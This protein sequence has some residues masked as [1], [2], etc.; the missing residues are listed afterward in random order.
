MLYDN[1][2]QG[3]F[4]KGCVYSAYAASTV[5]KHYL[6]TLP[7]ILVHVQVRMYTI[8]SLNNNE[9]PVCYKPV[10]V[11]KLVLSINGRHSRKSHTPPQ[12]EKNKYKRQYLQM[13]FSS[14]LFLILTLFIGAKHVKVPYNSC[15]I[16]DLV[17][18]N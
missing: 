13:V 9:I 18:L 4:K 2:M 11:L 15:Y 1:T 16:R 8:S 6:K 12:K 10:R 5:V 3:I 17:S 14:F 7:G